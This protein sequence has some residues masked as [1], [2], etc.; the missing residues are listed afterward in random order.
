MWYKIWIWLYTSSYFLSRCLS[1]RL[2]MMWVG[3]VV[4]LAYLGAVA[5]LFIC[6]QWER[7]GMKT[8][9]ISLVSAIWNRG[10]CP[11]LCCKDFFMTFLNRRFIL[12]MCI[13]NWI[14]QS[15]PTQE[16]EHGKGQALLVL[17]S[18]SQKVLGLLCAEFHLSTFS[19]MAITPHPILFGW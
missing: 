1:S 5:N 18:Q 7:K 2:I 17:E 3:F 15:V 14:L 10:K 12:I 19:C 11:S 6:N 13:F 9:I 8:D 4:V 16:Q